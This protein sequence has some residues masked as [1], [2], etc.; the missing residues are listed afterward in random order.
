MPTAGRS[1]N[2]RAIRSRDTT[3]ELAVRRLIHARGLRYRC[4]LRFKAGDV[5]V[6]PD[7]VFTKQKVA[8]FV[9]GCF[10][11]VCD[12]HGRRPS[13]NNQYWEPKLKRNLER[14]RE[15]TD[16]LRRQGWLVIRAW[17]HEEPSAVADLVERA[18][19]GG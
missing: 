19:R 6:R 11:H 8:L 12:Q 4:D 10:W 13:A 16:A 9:D 1:A 15:Q 7:V 5:I 2:M 18:V 14:D 17:E 3:P